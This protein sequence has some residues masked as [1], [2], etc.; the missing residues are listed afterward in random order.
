MDLE[1][2]MASELVHL[3]V[4]RKFEI[5]GEALNK[6][7]KSNPELASRIPDLPQIVAF[8]NLLIHQYAQVD[9]ATVWSIINKALPELKVAVDRLL[10]QAEPSQ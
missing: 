4:E 1:T 6:L 9:H 7:S 10:S 8:R 2:Y 5:I 3:A